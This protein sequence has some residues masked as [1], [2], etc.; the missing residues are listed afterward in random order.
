M[1]T[2]ETVEIGIPADE[3]EL[4]AMRRLADYAFS[5]SPPPL[6]DIQGMLAQGRENFR[7]ARVRGRAA[8]SL[9]I[10]PMGQWFGGR[11]V[12]MAGINAVAVAP[13][14]RA[15]GIATRLLRRMLEDV[16][17]Q[18]MPLSVLYPA[19]QPVYR[20][21]GYEQAG[22]HLAY[23][24]PVAAL[25]PRD[26]SLDIRPAEPDELPALRALYAERAR[27]TSGNLD[28]NEYMWSRIWSD[29]G[30]STVVNTYAVERDGAPEGYVAYHQA[31]ETGEQDRNIVARDLV[32]LTPDAARRLLSFFADHRSVVRNVTWAGA[33]ADPLL[34]HIPNQD[35]RVRW[36][37]QWM[38]R[39]V[40]VRA[41]LEARG[42][43]PGI[44]TE[45]HLRV[46]DDALP[47]NDGPFVLRVSGGVA[48]VRE[49]GEGRVGLDVRGLASIYSGYLSPAG[50][51]STGYIE[52]PVEDLA[53]LG[54][55]FAGPAPWM[56]DGF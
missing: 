56:A 1:A 6:P 24:Q 37:E 32:A 3:D 9:G 36:Y 10:I 53:A 21:A 23:F 12:P 28:R 55:V 18:G 4:R 2:A 44:E 15:A 39:L 30:G 31:Q 26:R 51:L 50:M 5:P 11:S 22:I 35:Y 48:E 38:L 16:R 41:A 42:Y 47:W 43:P 49:G 46:R 7:V 27:R 19:T 52:G 20:R 14:H 34:F 29:R 8:G 54:A 17:A 40:D 45:V 13:E 25:P 33:P